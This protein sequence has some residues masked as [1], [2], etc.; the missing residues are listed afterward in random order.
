MALGA[1]CPLPAVLTGVF[2]V[3]TAILFPCTAPGRS[4]FL[5]MPQA[6]RLGIEKKHKKNKYF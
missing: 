3:G 1:A 4:F 2:L 6:V 5:G